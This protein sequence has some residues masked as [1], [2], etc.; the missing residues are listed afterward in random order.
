ME[1]TPSELAEMYNKLVVK[2]E[3]LQKEHTQCQKVLTDVRI[4]CQKYKTRC[5]NLEAGIEKM[6]GVLAEYKQ[7]VTSLRTELFELKGEPD[8]VADQS[9]LHKKIVA[10]TER[11]R[12]GNFVVR[13]TVSMLHNTKDHEEMLK[14]QDIV[15]KL[16]NG[17][18]TEPEEDKFLAKAFLRTLEILKEQPKGKNVT[19]AIELISSLEV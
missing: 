1:F 4:D 19:E 11:G 10:L 16:H 2:F 3:K 5:K 6:N 17:N 15:E 12:L 14:V 7:Q 18:S 9:E 8:I 13:T